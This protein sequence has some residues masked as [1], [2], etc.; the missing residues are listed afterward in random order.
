MLGE[1]GVNAHGV[2]LGSIALRFFWPPSLMGA[3]IFENTK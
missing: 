2:V 3:I 1:A